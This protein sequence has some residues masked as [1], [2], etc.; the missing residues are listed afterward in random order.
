MQ[1][2]EDYKPKLNGDTSRVFRGTGGDN[3]EV[4][5]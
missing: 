4:V 5:H 1:G 2:V 3:G